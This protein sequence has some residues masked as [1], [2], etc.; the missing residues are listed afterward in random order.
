MFAAAVTHLRVY[1]ARFA[2][3]SGVRIPKMLA[4]FNATCSA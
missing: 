1:S 3:I 4:R 2:M